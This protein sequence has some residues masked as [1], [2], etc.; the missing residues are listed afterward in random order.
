MHSPQPSPRYGSW[1]LTSGGP[2]SGG[3]G[4]G[5]TGSTGSMMSGGGSSRQENTSAVSGKP[6]LPSAF[7]GSAPVKSKLAVVFAVRPSDVVAVHGRVGG[8]P[9]GPSMTQAS[10]AAVSWALYGGAPGSAQT[11]PM[12]CRKS[13]GGRSP[14]LPSLGGVGPLPDAE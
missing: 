5:S 2:S 7:G 3:P 1:S 8:A 6:G 9:T 4:S 11:T 14:G 13:G 10:G 12:H